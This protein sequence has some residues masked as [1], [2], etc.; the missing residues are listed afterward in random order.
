MAYV[1]IKMAETYSYLDGYPRLLRFRWLCW[2]WGTQV[3]HRSSTTT[4]DNVKSSAATQDSAGLLWPNPEG[5][6]DFP[7]LKET[8]K[9][10]LT[11]TRQDRAINPKML[12]VWAE[13]WQQEG[14]EQFSQWLASPQPRW[15]R[16]CTSCFFGDLTVVSR[17]WH[18]CLF[19]ETFIKHVK[20]HI[21]QISGEFEDHILSKPELNKLCF[22]LNHENT[23]RRLNKAS[24]YK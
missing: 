16:L 2:G 1:S 22:M 4:Q 9:T 23:F 5:L 10:D 11:L 3:I 15:R 12:T 13:S 17:I 8:E 14:M 7:V 24:H 20:C 19:G 21:Q 18:F 6:R